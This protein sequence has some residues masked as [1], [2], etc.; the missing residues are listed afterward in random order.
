MDAD[1]RSEC[2]TPRG[3]RTPLA[4]ASS[5]AAEGFRPGLDAVQP[6]S[7]LAGASPVMQ[8]DRGGEASSTRERLGA[9]P[10]ATTSLLT[11]ESNGITCVCSAAGW[12]CP[13]SNRVAVLMRSG[14]AVTAHDV[15][16]TGLLASLQQLRRRLS[17]VG[18]GSLH[19]LLDMEDRA[20]PV[21]AMDLA[22]PRAGLHEQGQEVFTYKSRLSRNVGKNGSLQGLCARPLFLFRLCRSV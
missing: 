18:S 17:G 19:A 3:A 10:P 11:K 9:L 21:A 1:A 2:S 8:P 5:P 12:P 22:R 14:R 4:R 13:V 7:P 6:G 20:E 16:L 15:C